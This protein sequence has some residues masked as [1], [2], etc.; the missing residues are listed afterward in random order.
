MS[1][2]DF[3]DG[4]GGEG[5]AVHGD[6][7]VPAVV[8]DEFGGGV[9]ELRG[10]DAV[11]GARGAAALHVAEDDGTGFQAGGLFDVAGEGLA[12][13]AEAPGVGGVGDDAFDDGL[14]SDGVGAFANGDEG[15]AAAVMTAAAADVADGVEVEG[16]FGDEDEVGA[17][18][19]AGVES[20]PSGVSSHGFED[21]DAVMG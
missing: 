9:A 10:Q 19:H 2:G 7:E 18:G 11:G 20:D 14:T 4:D 6:H 12:D 3:G 1:A 5:S 15:E 13:A 8:G 17:G 16:D 21:H